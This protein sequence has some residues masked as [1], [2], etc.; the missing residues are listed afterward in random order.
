MVESRELDLRTMEKLL[1]DEHLTCIV[2]FHAQ[3]LVE[4]TF[5]A[6]FEELCLDIPKIHSLLALW[7]KIVPFWPEFFGVDEDTLRRLDLLYIDAR[8]PGNLGLLPDGAPLDADARYFF[9]FSVELY[10]RTQKLLASSA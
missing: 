5:K 6:I 4:K 3:Q 9:T 10:E 7:K 8:Y 1:G 2:A